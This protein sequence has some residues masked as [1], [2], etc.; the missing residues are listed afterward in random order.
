L[1]EA[2]TPEFTVVAQDLTRRPSAS[3]GFTLLE[4]LV[5][6]VIIG[7]IAAMATLN[8]GV[9]TREKG[10]QKEVER[11]GVVITAA[12]EEAQMQG[13][14]IGLTFYAH[15]YRFNAFDPDKQVWAP[16]EGDEQFQAHAFPPQTIAE[17]N[18]EGRPVRLE[19]EPP[20][21]TQRQDSEDTD[22]DSVSA[23]TSKSNKT[24][25]KPADK[26]KPPPPQV[27]ILS[28]GDVTP[29]VLRLKPGAGSPGMQL[30]V[31]GNG[32]V[33]SARDEI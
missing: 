13:R 22:P 17:L 32:D 19:E 15:E 20:V 2:A 10:V 1:P 11:L 14:E 5:V 7:I 9:A 28:S 27:M 12:R 3:G 31:T 26:K 30:T 23:K 16:L 25:D 24:K 33:T 4:L 21:V 6:V 29:F 8:I 18:L